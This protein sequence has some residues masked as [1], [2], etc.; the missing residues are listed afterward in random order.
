MA[1]KAYLFE[2]NG[3]DT[4]IGT[5]YWNGL[6]KG[7]TAP[8]KILYDLRRMEKAYLE[9]DRVK[10]AVTEPIVVAEN[11]GPQIAKGNCSFVID[12]L[13]EKLAES[14]GSHILDVRLQIICEEKVPLY[15]RLYAKIS[16]TGENSID[17]GDWATGMA[18]VDA[19][20][21]DFRFQ[22]N[23]YLPFEGMA[24]SGA[25]FTITITA[26]SNVNFSNAKLIL[27]VTHTL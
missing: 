8:E 5:D 27:F 16:S 23:Q 10:V 17:F 20:K 18:L 4:F 24:V 14:A 19:D 3:A 21:F 9:N 11:L 15:T 1:E 25:S 12:G 13:A 2:I 7:L 26:N 22:G 6:Y